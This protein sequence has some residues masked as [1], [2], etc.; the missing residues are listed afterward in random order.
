MG[1]S[2]SI[3][4]TPDPIKSENYCSFVG[5][6]P[7]RR[8]ACNTFKKL[9]NFTDN[10]LQSPPVQTSAIWWGRRRAILCVPNLDSITHMQKE[11]NF[12]LGFDIGINYPST[13][14]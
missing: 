2:L 6:Q 4:V 8:A 12:K 14:F 3:V 10:Q 7:A 11:A 9:E 1:P 13:Q 5:R